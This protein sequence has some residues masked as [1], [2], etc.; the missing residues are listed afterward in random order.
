MVVGAAEKGCDALCLAQMHCSMLRLW[1]ITQAS[2]LQ[3]QQVGP[4][5]GSFSPSSH[6]SHSQ[7]QPATLA[8]LKVDSE[9]TS[10]PTVKIANLV[11]MVHDGLS[12]FAASCPGFDKAPKLIAG[13]PLHS[14]RLAA[15]SLL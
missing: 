3:L 5:S 8:L 11:L 12:T 7:L 13:G 9:L 4:F 1:L 10:T 2:R 14:D 6:S 15:G